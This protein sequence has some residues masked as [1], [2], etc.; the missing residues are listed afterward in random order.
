MGQEFT[1][2]LYGYACDKARVIPTRERTLSSLARG[3]F[4]DDQQKMLEAQTPEEKQMND[5]IDTLQHWHFEPAN[6]NKRAGEY[7]SCQVDR[8]LSHHE[9]YAHVLDLPADRLVTRDAWLTALELPDDSPMR[10]NV[11]FLRVLDEL[12]APKYTSEHKSQFVDSLRYCMML[13]PKKAGYPQGQ[14]HPEEPAWSDVTPRFIHG[15]SPEATQ[16]DFVRRFP[17]LKAP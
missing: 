7:Q 3:M 12:C 14:G 9:E 8:L 17:H 13:D 1:D 5:Y 15:S 6:P 10:R 11:R 16:E 4:K 2:L